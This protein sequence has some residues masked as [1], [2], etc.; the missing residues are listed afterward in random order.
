MKTSNAVMP[1]LIQS[2]RR[3]SG[4]VGGISEPLPLAPGG[5]LAGGFFS[6]SGSGEF[7]LSG[8]I[9]KE[10]NYWSPAQ[11]KSAYLKVIDVHLSILKRLRARHFVRD[12]NRVWSRQRRLNF[13]N[14]KEKQ[15]SWSCWRKK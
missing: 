6:G 8:F 3:K 11:A 14:S 7:V 9:V 10:L 12:S 2:M 15:C 4:G 5:F 1:K 13:Q